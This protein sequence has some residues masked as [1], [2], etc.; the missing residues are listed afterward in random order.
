MEIAKLIAVLIFPLLIPTAGLFILA[1]MRGRRD[2]T[3]LELYRFKPNESLLHQWGF[4]L[5]IFIPVFYF[6]GFG[7]IAW[8]DY[9]LLLTGQGLQTFIS[10]S[11][12]PLALLSVAIP[13]AAIVASFHSTEQTAAQIRL[14]SYYSH[15]NDF[16][17]HLDKTGKNNYL[18]RFEVAH[19][20][21]PQLYLIFFNGRPEEGVP[22]LNLDRFREVESMLSDAR[23]YIHLFF[24][25]K[26]YGNALYLYLSETCP[27]LRKI[28]GRFSFRD[29]SAALKDKSST[30]DWLGK[31]GWT[32]GDSAADLI[33][34]YR[35]ALVWYLDLCGAAGYRSPDFSFV[36]SISYFETTDEFLLMEGSKYIEQIHRDDIAKF[37]PTQSGG[38]ER[39]LT[40]Q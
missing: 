26:E 3:L 11:T 14:T 34:V 29:V 4:W 37:S 31:V 7:L 28:M 2:V 21:H 35:Y 38:L 5:S 18:G 20:V 10:I 30:Y 12:L 13:A 1:R 16:H 25:E 19:N 17:A 6:I 23:K 24:E 8:Q 36:K 15:K 27:A 22:R 32:V 40:N 33:A 39:D 9:D